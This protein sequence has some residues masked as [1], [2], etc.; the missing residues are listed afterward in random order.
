MIDQGADFGVSGN[1]AVT[2]QTASEAAHPRPE[3]SVGYL[4]PRHET[5][6][7]VAVIWQNLLGLERVGIHDNFFELGGDSLL[8]TRI[9]SR[10]RETFDV[11]LPL[12]VLLEA[13]T[14]ED[15]AAFITREQAEMSREAN[16]ARTL[17]ASDREQGE[18]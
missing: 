7:G 8:G 17:T 16:T 13:P 12:R 1:I 14:V 15:M 5:E 2:Q 3:L 4:A 9:I 11:A 10:V 18:L 6:H